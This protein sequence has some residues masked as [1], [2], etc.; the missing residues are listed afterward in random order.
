MPNSPVQKRIIPDG[1]GALRPASLVRGA[2]AQADAP[3]R[4]YPPWVPA[5]IDD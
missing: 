2:P 3:G 1:I 5:I 4:G